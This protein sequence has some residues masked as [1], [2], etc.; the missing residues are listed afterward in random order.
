MTI[1]IKIICQ[2]HVTSLPVKIIKHKAFIRYLTHLISPSIAQLNN[3]FSFFFFSSLHLI[4]NHRLSIIPANYLVARLLA[5]STCPESSP[6]SQI[7]YNDTTTTG[8]SETVAGKTYGAYFNLM[9]W[10]CKVWGHLRLKMRKYFREIL[11][12]CKKFRH[13]LR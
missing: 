3:T 11:D 8:C 7:R 9:R 10:R 6:S 13:N 4:S 1:A 12:K 5:V 2:K